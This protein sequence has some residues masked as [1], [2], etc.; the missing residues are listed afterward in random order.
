[1]FQY[2][3]GSYC[4]GVFDNYHKGTLLGGVATRNMLVKV[5]RVSTHYSSGSTQLSPLLCSL[6]S[7][8]LCALL[9]HLTLLVAFDR[10]CTLTC[11]PGTG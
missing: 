3:R 4:L 8:Y 2:G 10:A 9:M 6:Y 11:Q 7:R 5:S 1:M